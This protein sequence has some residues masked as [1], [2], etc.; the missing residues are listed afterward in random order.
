MSKR[1]CNA[2]ETWNSK[3][4]HIE[5]LQFIESILTHFD[6]LKRLVSK[7]DTLTRLRISLIFECDKCYVSK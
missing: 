5:N 7:I 2:K 4:N 1:D 3:F 6:Y